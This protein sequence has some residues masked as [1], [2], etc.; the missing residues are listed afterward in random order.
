MF[1]NLV[2]QMLKLNRKL[3]YAVIA[4]KHMKG[5]APGQL[6]T[7]KEIS[8]VYHTPFDATARVLQIM[9]QKGLLKSEQGVQGGYIIVRDLQ[10]TSLF[11]LVEYV[12]GPV[13]MAKCFQGGCEIES[14]CNIKSPVMFLRTRLIDFYKGL[15]LWD[16]LDSSARIPAHTMTSHKP[17][18]IKFI[19]SKQALAISDLTTARRDD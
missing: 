8:E 6:T 1:T 2:I 19:E 7:A 15:T 9:T 18:P 12:L 14:S 11:D 16:L 10:R 4:L 13:E 17:K 5:K 3:E